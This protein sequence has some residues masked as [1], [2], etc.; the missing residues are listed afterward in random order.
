MWLYRSPAHE[1]SLRS[2][3]CMQL[4]ITNI[5]PL[6]VLNKALCAGLL[7][8]VPLSSQARMIFHQSNGKLKSQILVK[9]CNARYHK[10]IGQ[11]M[12]KIDFIINH[13]LTQSKRINP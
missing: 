13:C 10:Q 2:D 7:S 1:D 6:I 5:V 4:F 11:M 8:I 9:F 12:N 3:V